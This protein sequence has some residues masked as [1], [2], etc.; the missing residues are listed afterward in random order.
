[1]RKLVLVFVLVLSAISYSQEEYGLSKEQSS[2]IASGTSSLDDW[3]VTVEDLKGFMVFD[4]RAN[5]I[6]NLKIE[7]LSE[8]LKGN[9]KAMNK[10]IYEALKTEEFESIEFKCLS[11]ESVSTADEEPNS[12]NLTGELLLANVTKSMNVLVNVENTAEGIMLKGTTELDMLDYGIE[13]PK[14]LFG[15]VKV[16]KLVNITFELLFIKTK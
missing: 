15:A 9:K 13:P 16:K 6:K 14:A 1:M 4:E 11:S 12:F 5:T 10:K 3:K 7:V 8:S 2:L